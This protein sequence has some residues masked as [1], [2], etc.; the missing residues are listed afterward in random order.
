VVAALEAP[1]SL[2]ME[3]SLQ[4]AEQA[5]ASVPAVPK[6]VEEGRI[7]LARGSEVSRQL[8]EDQTREREAYSVSPQGRRTRTQRAGGVA[9]LLA[10]VLLAWAASCLRYRPDLLDRPGQMLSFSALTLVLVGT[11]RLCVIKGF[12]PLWVPLPLMIM[13][14]CL[15]HNQFVGLGAAVFFALLVRLAS[16]G[17]DVEF[18]VLLLGGLTTALLTGKVRTRSTLIKDGVLVGLVQFFAVW[19]LTLMTARNQWPGWNFWRSSAMGDSLVALANGVL[20]GFIV[21]GL[22]PAIETLFGVT[23]DIRLLEWSDPNQPLLQQLLLEAPG[24]YHHSM[25]VGSLAADAAEAIGANPLLAR[26]SAYFHDVGKLKKPEYFA[27][28]LP[29]G[30]HN[31]HD[32]L[33]PTMSTLI[34]TAHPKDGAE[35]AAEHGVPKPVRDIVLQSHGTGVLRYFL[36]KAQEEEGEQG[37]VAERNFRYRLMKPQSKEA[38]VVLLCDA[39]EGA[40][41]S[42]QSPSPGQVRNLVH[43]IILDRLHDGQLDESGLTITDLKTLEDSLVHGLLAVFHH[44]VRYPGQEELEREPTTQPDVRRNGVQEGQP[45]A[46]G[47]MQPAKRD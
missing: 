16:P 43:Q 44:R 15:V 28:N 6:F 47:N 33:S 29:P 24:T 7:I 42:M 11:A 5:A 12:S 14:M 19:G 25:V 27:E 18:L 40:A 3:Q 4:E 26:V 21:S 10:I 31:P 9:V 1:L 34:I 39:V 23:T 41:R 37:E 36:G 2:D 38:A 32:D 8:L 30:G 22:L 17:A 45:G 35:M 46:R 13:V 20:A